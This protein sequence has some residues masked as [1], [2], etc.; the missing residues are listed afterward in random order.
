M[1]DASDGTADRQ[2]DLE[3]T[4][5][6]ELEAL[7]QEVEEKYD[8]ENFGP[9]DMA[10]M[11]AQEW[12]AAFDPDSWIVGEE[13]LT[14]VE[15][16]L[17]SRVARR[18]IFGVVERVRVEGEPHILVYSDEGYALVTPDGDLQGEGTVYRDVRPTLVLCSMD[19]FEVAE[20]PEDFS[21]PAPEEVVDQSSELGNLMLQIIAAG[22][23]LGGIT[24]LVLWLFTDLI[25]FASNARMNIVPPVASAF[26]LLIGIFLFVVVANARLSD[27]FRAEEYRNRLRAVREGGRPD[28]VPLDDGSGTA[29]ESNDRDDSNGAR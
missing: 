25:P 1:A 29:L 5:E 24:L 23:I 26:F 14:R 17:K 2:T 18:E 21:L 15:K 16:E 8:F 11:S 10:E 20:P 28:F 19:D 12:E 13:L 6:A 27:R 22:Q 4:E 9:S 3:D 7:R